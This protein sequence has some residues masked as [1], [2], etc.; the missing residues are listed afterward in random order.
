MDSAAWARL[1]ADAMLLL[2]IAVVLFVILGLLLSLLGGALKWQWVRNRWFRGIHLLTIAVIVGQAWLGIICPLTTWEMQ[3]RRAAGQ[4]T[5][6]ETFVAYW[7]G[8]LLFIDADPWVFILAYSLFGGLVL[9]SLWCVPVRWRKRNR[10][11][12]HSNASALT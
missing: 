6:D 2:H 10:T 4:Q 7:L 8:N 9:L 11:Q 3:L 12:P 5:Y 1:A